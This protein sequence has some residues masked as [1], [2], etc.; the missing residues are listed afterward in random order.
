[1]SIVQKAANSLQQ[2]SLKEIVNHHN[3]EELFKVMY[4][5][6]RYHAV[7]EREKTFALQL[8]DKND[9][10]KKIATD[11]KLSFYTAIL[12]C[13]LNRMTLN[14]ELKLAYLVPRDGAVLFTTSYMGKL[15]I[16][17]NAKA[18][19]YYKTGK[20][21]YNCDTF[22]ETNG[23]VTHTRMIPKPDTAK[24]IGAY[25]IVVIKDSTGNNVERHHFMEWS[26]I[27]KRREKSPTKNKSVDTWKDW[28]EDMALKTVI[29]SLYKTLK[30]SDDLVRIETIA[31]QIGI[32][33]VSTQ[34]SCDE[35]GVEY[36]NIE[37]I[38]VE[39]KTIEPKSTGDPIM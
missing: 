21:V 3:V 39:A 32:P 24:P 2:K 1:M 23:M 13:A 11:N 15:E 34:F 36:Q 5:E 9:Y 35:D 7:F 12:N 10:L 31:N 16:L 26:E 18:I 25:V 22:S 19:E 30:K 20:V 29:N 14:P 28:A 37:A 4:G 38:T 27:L 17:Q 6:N 33:S 8:L